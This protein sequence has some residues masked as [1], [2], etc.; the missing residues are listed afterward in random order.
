MIDEI[1]T[2]I[3]SYSYFQA[4]KMLDSVR[5]DAVNDWVKLYPAPNISFPGS[6]IRFT[7]MDHDGNLC[8]YMNFLGLY[9]VNAPVPLYIS[10]YIAGEYPGYEK[11]ETLLA[12]FSTRLYELLFQAWAKFRPAQLSVTQTEGSLYNTI[13]SSV[14]G[15]SDAVNRPYLRKYASLLG[16]RHKNRVSLER[17]L[18]SLLAVS[19]VR[20]TEFVPKWLELDEVPVTGSNDMLLGVTTVAG[21]RVLDATGS[22]EVSIGPL[23]LDDAVTIYRD[24]EQMNT[25]YSIVDDFVSGEISCTVDFICNA[26]L[27]ICSLGDDTA[28]LGLNTLLGLSEGDVVIRA[29]RPASMNH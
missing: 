27:T 21:S 5:P 8:L 6:D 26:D 29:S 1:C 7:R 14:S 9:G 22:I 16:A 20:V 13:L 10:E 28:C 24:K 19:A 15:R 3:S 12:L 11:L 18:K 23:D 17:V 25:V 4:L 2:N